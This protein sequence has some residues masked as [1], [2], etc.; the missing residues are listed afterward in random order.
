MSSRICSSRQPTTYESRF[1]G[2]YIRPEKLDD[3]LSDK[4]GRDNF[5]VE[6]RNDRY[7]VTAKSK[8]TSQDLQKCF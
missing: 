3:V 8:L 4:F 6:M 1:P 7:K 5:T 2:R